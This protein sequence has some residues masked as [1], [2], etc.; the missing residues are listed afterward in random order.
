M[1]QTKIKGRKRFVRS[2]QARKI[3]DA[4]T[5]YCVVHE[6]RKEKAFASEF[7]TSIA[8]PSHRQ[9]QHSKNNNSNKNPSLLRT[10]T[11]LAA[12]NLWMIG[13]AHAND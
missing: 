6:K 5:R 8:M 3:L 1:E 13:T 12:T 11:Q 9:N 4:N 2:N 7:L 10:S